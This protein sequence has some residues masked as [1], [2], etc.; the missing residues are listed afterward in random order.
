MNHENN[1]HAYNSFPGAFQMH[2]PIEAISATCGLKPPT[3]LSSREGAS[4]I[5]S[6]G[7]SVCEF[8]RSVRIN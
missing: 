4:F 7:K 6:K 8:Y 3:S 5:P 1:K 2:G